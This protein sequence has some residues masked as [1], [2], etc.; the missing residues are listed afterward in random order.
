MKQENSLCLQVPLYHQGQSHLRCHLDTLSQVVISP[1]TIQC[2]DMQLNTKHD[3]MHPSRA[4]AKPIQIILDTAHLQETFSSQISTAHMPRA[5]DDHVFIPEQCWKKGV[6]KDWRNYPSLHR[7]L[8]HISYWRPLINIK[9]TRKLSTVSDIIRNNSLR[10]TGGSLC[11]LLASCDLRLHG[12]FSALLIP[13]PNPRMWHHG[14]V[15]WRHLDIS[16]AQRSSLLSSPTSIYIAC[17]YY[18]YAHR[19]PP[20]RGGRIVLHGP[21]H[22]FL[23]LRTGTRPGVDERIS[24]RRRNFGG[25]TH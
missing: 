15:L 20:F 14:E 22:W 24:A 8:S 23:V 25:Q 1:I 7:P 5:V 16:M 19:M 6:T 9:C 4:A 18:M 12:S 17:D 21:W 10:T 2:F 11:P 3:A 13:A